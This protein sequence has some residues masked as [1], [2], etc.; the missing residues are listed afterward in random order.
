MSGFETKLSTPVTFLI[1]FLSLSAV[2]SKTSPTILS[3]NRTSRLRAC[4]GEER[5]GEKCCRTERGERRSVAIDDA[6]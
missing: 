2:L 1:F 6:C 3:C 4:N 5:G